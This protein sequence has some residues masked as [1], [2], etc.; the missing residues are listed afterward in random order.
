MWVESTRVTI[1]VGGVHTG[2]ESGL[3]L[4]CKQG[5]ILLLGTTPQSQG[6]Q[7]NHEHRSL[8]SQR[9]TSEKSNTLIPYK[10]LHIAGTL[11][12]SNAGMLGTVLIYIRARGFVYERIGPMGRGT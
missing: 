9:H 2:V 4:S 12:P 11:K 5:Y 10:T 8:W 3:E 1:L 6:P 7:D